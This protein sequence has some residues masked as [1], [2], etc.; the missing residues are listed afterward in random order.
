MCQTACTHG[1]VSGIIQYYMAQ[2]QL[3]PD[4]TGADLEAA[5]KLQEELMLYAQQ[6]GNAATLAALA[7][8]TEAI[9]AQHSPDNTV[10]DA[11]TSGNDQLPGDDSGS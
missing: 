4:T 1:S 5:L 9:L 11:A 10:R 3:S 8:G 2:E 6:Q 7:N